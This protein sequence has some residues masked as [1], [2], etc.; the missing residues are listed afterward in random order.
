MPNQRDL[1]SPAASAA[2]VERRA[3]KTLRPLSVLFVDDVE[4]A[5]RMYSRYFTFAGIGVTTAAN[6]REALEIARQYPPTVIVTDL[7]MPQMNGLEFTRHV[8]ADRALRSIP[9]IAITAFDR[10]WS[11][12]DSVAAGADVYLRKPCLPS[13]LVEA[14]TYLARP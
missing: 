10:D 1:Y 8:R 6:G 3:K 5:R 13:T 2:D 11:E 7:A 9:V 4:E 12:Q 14:V